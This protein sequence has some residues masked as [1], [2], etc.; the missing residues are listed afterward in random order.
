ME[1]AIH[2]GFVNGDVVFHNKELGKQTKILY[3][4]MNKSKLSYCKAAQALAKIRDEKLFEEDF[5]DKNGKG[6]FAEYCETVL[7]VPASTAYKIIKTAQSLLYPELITKDKDEFFQSFNDSA[8][9]ALVQV[10]DYDETKQFCDDNE[11]DETTP[12]RTVRA[13]VK[14]LMDL[15]K[16]KISEV[17]VGGGTESDE[18][19]DSNDASNGDAN[20]LDDLKEVLYTLSTIRDELPDILGDYRAVQ[21]IQDMFKKYDIV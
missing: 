6:S 14:E 17:D 18:M 13:K 1:L 16:G 21:L 12:V 11:I 3:S 10:G 9:G 5:T 19:S 7:N 15:R 2:V 20:A 8:L 4:E